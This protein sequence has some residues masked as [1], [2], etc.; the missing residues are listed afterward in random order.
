[1]LEM[2]RAE[3]LGG[4]DGGP[5]AIWPKPPRR[6]RGISP[7]VDPSTPQLWRQTKF[8]PLEAGVLTSGITSECIF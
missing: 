7:T 2:V 8:N 3:Q 4:D 1:M 5:V 6:S